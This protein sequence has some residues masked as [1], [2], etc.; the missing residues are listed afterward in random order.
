MLLTKDVL[1]SK[2]GDKFFQQSKLMGESSSQDG[3]IGRNPSLT[4]TY[5][6]KK[7]NNQS[8]INKQPETP[9]N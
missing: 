7:D 9:E 8:K 5:L 4:Y 3:G 1:L 2:W 6:Q